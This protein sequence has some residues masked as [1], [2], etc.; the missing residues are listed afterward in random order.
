VGK[1]GIAFVECRFFYFVCRFCKMQTVIAGR[2]L[3]LSLR[4]NL[5]ARQLEKQKVLWT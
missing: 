4:T 5:V 1:T 2:W 3:S